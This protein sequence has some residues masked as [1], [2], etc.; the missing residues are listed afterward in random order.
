M[1]Q[2]LV[3]SLSGKIISL[4]FLFNIILI[5]TSFS[6]QIEELNSGWFCKNVK[7]VDFTGVEI[8][9]YKEIDLATWLPATVPGTILT[10]LLEN[11]KVPDPFYGMNNEEIPDI[12]DTGR[13][14]YTYWLYKEFDLKSIKNDQIWLTFRGVNYASDI[15]LNG[16]KINFKTHHGMFLRQKY[17]VTSGIKKGKNRLGTHYNLLLRA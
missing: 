8:T 14:H 17:N 11:G 9:S 1:N 16:K 6:Q 13:D 2:N 12:Y 15:F 4:L 5:N 3:F 7:E 10:T